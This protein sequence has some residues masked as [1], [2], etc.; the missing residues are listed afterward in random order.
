MAP[1]LLAAGFHVEQHRNEPRLGLAE[2]VSHAG[3]Q[4]VRDHAREQAPRTHDDQV[5]PRYRLHGR[6]V[7]LGSRADVADVPD[8]RIAV[9]DVLLSHDAGPLDIHAGELAKG[10]WGSTRY[11][12]RTKL[13]HYDTLITSLPERPLVVPRIRRVPQS[14]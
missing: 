12:I 8:A 2:R 7:R 6:S 5:G 14:Y 1:R 11:V 13:L 9:G 10:Y 3:D 4:E